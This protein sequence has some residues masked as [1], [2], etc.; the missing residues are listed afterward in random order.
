MSNKIKQIV[1][2]HINEFMGKED[3]LSEMRMKI[4]KACPLFK[5]THVGPICN[6]AL[7]LNPQTNETKEIPHEGFYRGCSCRLN[8]KTRLVGAECP[9]HKW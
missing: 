1:Q 2:G 3:E 7:Y 8:A 6:S 4:C 9:A 5:T